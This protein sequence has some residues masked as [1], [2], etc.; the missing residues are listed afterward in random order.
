M[1][2]GVILGRRRSQ[3]TKP[4]LHFFFSVMMF[5]K[6]C[7]SKD[8]EPSRPV[9]DGSHQVGPEV[10]NAWQILTWFVRRRSPTGFTKG[11]ALKRNCWPSGKPGWSDPLHLMLWDPTGNPCPVDRFKLNTR[12]NT[13]WV[14]KARTQ[15]PFRLVEM[16]VWSEVFWEFLRQELWVIINMGPEG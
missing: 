6:F 4:I 8:P 3:C 16:A 7:L 5:S 10:G 12:T 13:N 14:A 2:N 1:V 9:W 15:G 11:L